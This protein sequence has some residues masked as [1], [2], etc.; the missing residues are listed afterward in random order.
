MPDVEDAPDFIKRF[1]PGWVWGQVSGKVI[2][3]EATG[4][5]SVE[6]DAGGKQ[7]ATLSVLTIHP[8][9]QDYVRCEILDVEGNVEFEPI[10]AATPV[11]FYAVAAVSFGRGYVVPT[12]GKVRV[13]CYGDRAKKFSVALGLVT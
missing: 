3:L 11:N 5:G 10:P 8:A 12:D 2:K 6:F 9:E 7:L 13:I 1:L 4:E